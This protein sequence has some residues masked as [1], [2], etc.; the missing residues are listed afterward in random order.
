MVCLDEHGYKFVTNYDRLKN[1][2]FPRIV[3]K[4]N[5]YSMYNINLYTSN[6]R[7]DVELIEGQQYKNAKSKLKFKCLIHD[8]IFEMNWNNFSQGKGCPTCGTKANHGEGG[9]NIVLAERNKDEYLSIPMNL[10]VI[11]CTNEV[12]EF[13]KIGLTKNNVETR[14]N[15]KKAMPYNYEEVYFVSGDKYNFIYLEEELHKTNE[16]YSYI[17]KIY[18][19]GY[20]ECFSN[21]NLERIEQIINKYKMKIAI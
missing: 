7:D 11:K 20:T 6:N 10:Y 21:L 17:P 19:E 14:F 8:C 13:Y 15:C 2:R 16:E 18:F 3:D 1:N 4:T 5:P 9:Y 12:E